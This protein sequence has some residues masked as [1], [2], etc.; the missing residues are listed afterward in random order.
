MTLRVTPAMEA[1]LPGHIRTL[2]ELI[3]AQKI[4]VIQCTAMDR[5]SR[6]SGKKLKRPTKALKTDSRNVERG[7]LSMEATEPKINWRQAPESHDY[8]AAAS[9]LA[10]HYC[11]DVVKRLVKRLRKAPVIEFKAKDVFRASG[12]S[13][14]GV[15]NFHVVKDSDK[16]KAKMQVSP[17]LLVRTGIKVVIADGYHRMCAIYQLDEDAVIMAKIVDL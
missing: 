4:A 12:L 17:I 14:L 6:S 7:V 15:S 2:K 8:P 16:I 5:P 3:S 11:D 9:Y 1:G 10:L 13:L